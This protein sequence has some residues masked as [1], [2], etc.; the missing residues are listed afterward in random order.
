MLVYKQIPQQILR[1]YNNW[2]QKRSV[3]IERAKKSWEYYF[4]DVD[5]TGTN[6]T[7]EQLEIITGGTNIPVTIN[8]VHP[9]ANQKLALLLHNRPSIKV[10][11]MDGRALSEAEVLDKAKHAVMLQSQSQIQLEQ[12]I[13]DMLI[14]GWGFTDVIESNS[15]TPGELGVAIEHVPYDFVLL[16]ANSKKPTLADMEGYFLEKEM[17]VSMVKK[18]WPYIANNLQDEY[19]RP[20]DLLS[21]GST[22]FSSLDLT[23]KQ[24]ID[25]YN[26]PKIL[27][28]EYY[29]KV[30]TTLY[31]LEDEQS[32]D[33]ERVFA[34][35]LPDDAKPL[36]ASAFDQWQDTFVRK[37]LIF[38]DTIVWVEMMP[39][40]EW[41][42]K[43]SCFE[44]GGSPYESKGM[45]HF[46]VGMQDAYDKII[47]LLITNG[48]L[49]NNAGWKAP[50]GSIPI[51][52]VPKWQAHGND[53]HFV[54]QYIPKVIEG[55]V[56]VP[57]RDQVG[58]LGNFYNIIL[59]ML[60]GGMEFSSGITA[61]LNTN[62]IPVETFSTLQQ[63]QSAAM[64]RVMLASAHINSMLESL[65]YT[66]VEMLVS[67]MKGNAIY[68]FF[69]EKGV[70][71]EVQVAQN[72]VKSFKQVRYKVVMIPSTENPSQRIAVAQE[73]F[74]VAQ[75]SQDPAAREL[76]MMKGM[77]MSDIK[78]FQ[79]MKQ[80]LDVNKRLSS[81]LQQQEQEL[82]RDKELLKQM[83][84]RVINAE[85]QL[86]IEQ[87]K[88]DALVRMAR[89]IG[90]S[91]AEISLA[92][93]MQVMEEQQKVESN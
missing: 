61:I 52:E 15:E 8:F 21:L 91:E 93:D 13:R 29:D 77:E 48:I 85:L 65:G 75:S 78:E 6:F 59:E 82:M 62:E 1:N 35:N 32:G 33:V 9:I 44:W 23:D 51:E 57:E 83:E 60:K 67:Y 69:D 20:V 87:A 17:L 92:R 47:Q 71:N 50:I 66:L 38:N 39:I 5:G 53:P 49:T 70:R 73:M 12:H 55:H 3:W 72:M 42:L 10:L 4:N 80:E 63:Y 27:V 31:F 41:S 37:T 11:S 81:Q 22:S 74:K 89:E 19:G 84:N 2:K 43:G 56:F 40:T 46:L 28:R 24:K 88:A 34:E 64:Q 54:K 7:K 45:I 79:D 76:F 14:T 16:D 36:L 68:T 25:G 86:K 26:E 30:Y 18:Y 58:Q 90:K